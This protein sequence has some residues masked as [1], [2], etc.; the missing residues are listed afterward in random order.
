MYL[1]LRLLLLLKWVR[2]KR[3]FKEILKEITWQWLLFFQI[4]LPKSHSGRN[5]GNASRIWGLIWNLVDNSWRDAVPFYSW[6]N[7]A[8]M[9]ICSRKHQKLVGRGHFC[10]D[11]PSPHICMEILLYLVQVFKI[12]T[13]AHHHHPPPTLF[14]SDII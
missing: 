3:T 13:A 8:H 1:K 5:L 9:E 4:S 12:K 7:R 11:F 2:E 10:S 14:T 6:W